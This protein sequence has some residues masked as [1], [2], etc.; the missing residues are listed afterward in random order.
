MAEST[1]VYTPDN[2]NGGSVPA[3]LAMQNG[4]WGNGMGGWGSG[5]LGFILGALLGNGGFGNGFGWGGGNGAAAALG[6][7]A[8]ANN[9]TDLIMNAINGTDADVRLLATTLNSD[10][11]SVRLAINTVQGAIATLSAQ[12]G[13][14][15]QQII[16]AIQMGDTSLSRQ[17]C[18]C[19]CEMRQLTME[20]GYQNQLRTVEQTNTL[21]SAIAGASQRNVDAIADLK[22]TM[23]QEFCNVK[24]REMQDKINSLTANNTLL[25]SQI[26]NANQT[27][28]IAGLIAPI[29]KEV[30]D[31]KCK[32]PN[33]VSVNYPNLVAVSTTPNIGFG[34]GFGWGGFG[35]GYGFGYGVPGGSYWG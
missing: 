32:L 27:A 15:G 1:V 7:Q 5:I 9:N 18:E 31:I 4:G 3:W 8:T 2:N 34:N 19:C 11:D 6:A 35:G 25:R 30:D 23:V 21:G 17:L 20:Q 29:A 12:V 24:E 33:T 26:D 13:L 16:N 14:S 28:Q 10:V 22:T